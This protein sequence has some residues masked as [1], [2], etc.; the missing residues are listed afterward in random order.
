MFRGAWPY[1]ELTREAFTAVV[2]MLAD[3]FHTRRGR[4]GAYL[5]SYNFV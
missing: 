3:G 5:H 2:K 1:R 4:R